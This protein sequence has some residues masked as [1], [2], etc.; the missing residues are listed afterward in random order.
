MNNLITKL[1]TRLRWVQY[2][3]NLTHLPMIPNVPETGHVSYRLMAEI[4]S[5]LENLIPFFVSP[6]PS[7]TKSLTTLSRELRNQFPEYCPSFSKNQ[8]LSRYA[9]Q[10]CVMLQEEHPEAFVV[11]PNNSVLQQWDPF[12]AGVNA[13]LERLIW[14][15]Y[16][17][18][19]NVSETHT[20]TRSH[21]SSDVVENESRD[22]YFGLPVSA[23]YER[24]T[25]NSDNLYDD[26]TF[27][28]DTYQQDISNSFLLNPWP[29]SI[30]VVYFHTR[31]PQYETALYRAMDPGENDYVGIVFPSFAEQ[32]AFHRENNQ[33]PTSG[34]IEPSI[35]GG[36]WHRSSVVLQPGE[37]VRA[38][39]EVTFP[40]ILKTELLRQI[41]EDHPSQMLYPPQGIRGI[42]TETHCAVFR[43]LETSPS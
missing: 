22:E 21:F 6:E 42:F 18:A 31:H 14:F 19:R 16:S 33:S 29:R 38:F 43:F 15:P 7:V 8:R 25:S 37:E 41:A 32:E 12:A 13:I 9:N 26:R 5:L 27:F 20:E 28:I 2:I 30:E 23:F 36:L 11:R 40:T 35:T 10:A 1:N 3:G 34:L 24:G 4:L 39:P 17:H